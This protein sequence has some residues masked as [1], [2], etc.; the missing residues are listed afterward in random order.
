MRH[1]PHVIAFDQELVDRYDSEF[2]DESNV[3]YPAVDAFDKEQGFHLERHK[4]EH[5]ARVLACPVKQHRACW[6]HGR[7]IYAA[8]RR[9]IAAW[10]ALPGARTP[11][12]F[13]D[14][15]TAKGFSALM[16]QY[17][18]DDSGHDVEWFRVISVD[19]IDPNARVPRNTIAERDGP[20]TLHEIL[21]PWKDYAKRIRFLKSTGAAW[22]KE[23]DKQRI[24]FAFIDGKHTYQAVHE[25]LGLIAK[26]QRRNEDV[27]VLDDVQ[28]DGVRKALEDFRHAYTWR[29]IDAI[30]AKGQGR[31]HALRSYAIAVRR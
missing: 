5:A 30:P 15:G 21:N 29:I 31:D 26:N 6:Q 23:H 22:L 11:M 7:V 3:E 9:H 17:A 28:I 19:V 24:N 1:E 25:E 18:I 4:L 10:D 27:V 16:M 8:L 12:T 14:I 2:Y 20:R 13:L